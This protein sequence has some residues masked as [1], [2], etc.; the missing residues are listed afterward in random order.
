MSRSRTARLE[1]R[2]APEALQ[3]VK[4]AADLQGRSLSDF[5]VDSALSAAQRTLEDTHLL[6]LALEDQQALANA[7]LNPPPLAPA[8]ER[9][10]DRQRSIIISST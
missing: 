2:I 9:A 1:A 5:V 4:R 7:I 6:R 3:I 10:I 8:L